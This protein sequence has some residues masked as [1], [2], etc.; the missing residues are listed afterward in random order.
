MVGDQQRELLE[1]VVAEQVGPRQR[2][3]VDAGAGDEAIG[4]PRVGARHRR[5]AH[6]HVRVVRAHASRPAFR[7]RRSAA[8]RRAAASSLARRL[9]AHGRARPRRRRTGRWLG[10]MWELSLAAL[11]LL[12]RA[13]TATRAPSW[14]TACAVPLSAV[15]A[16]RAACAA[17]RRQRAAAQPSRCVDLDFV[18]D[19]PR[20]DEGGAQAEA[21]AAAHAAAAAARSRDASCT[22][23]STWRR[24]CRCCSQL[25]SQQAFIYRC[26]DCAQ[27][28]G[29]KLGADLVM[30]TWVQKVSE[31]I[32]NFNV[33]V[34]DVA[35]G[36]LDAV[37]VGRHARQQR[38]VVDR[39]RSPTWCATWPSRRQRNPRYG[40]ADDAR[41]RPG[42]SASTS[43]TSARSSRRS[44]P[45]AR[46]RRRPR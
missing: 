28:V 20:P 21:L 43:R 38:R 45:S 41:V 26:D 39:A 11:R 14:P 4:Q 33:E 37:E 6:A 1:V 18:D 8:A 30:T 16:R 34:H 24:R 25:R 35:K 46:R 2:G 42:C 10:V 19:N 5:G 12:W 9:R 7:R 32:L 3:L 15:A 29:R 40:A 27:Q 22:A 17:W 13:V 36:A 31:L 23:C 44:R